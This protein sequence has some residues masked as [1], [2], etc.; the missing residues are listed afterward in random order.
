MPDINWNGDAGTAP[1]TSRYD[2]ANDNLVLAETGAGTVLL[3]YDGSEWTVVGQVN[4]DNIQTDELEAATQNSNE[5]NLTK[6][7]EDGTYT[8]IGEAMAKEPANSDPNTT[9]VIEPKATPYQASGQYTASWSKAEIAAAGTGTV[10]GDWWAFNQDSFPVVIEYDDAGTGNPLITFDSAAGVIRGHEWRGI[11]FK[12][13]TNGGGNTVLKYTTGNGNANV[14]HRFEG[15][16]FYQF[17]GPGFE[18]VESNGDAYNFTFKSCAGVVG[19]TMKFPEQTL[20]DGDSIFQ[21]ISESNQF[22]GEF[23]PLSAIGG[24]MD[25]S[26][27]ENGVIIDGGC[28]LEPRNF[29]GNGNAGQIGVRVDDTTGG[30]TSF[31]GGRVSNWDVGVELTAGSDAFIQAGR[32]KSNTDDVRLNGVIGGDPHGDTRIYGTSK[33]TAPNATNDDTGATTFS[34]RNLNAPTAGEIAP[35]EWLFDRNNNRIIHRDEITGVVDFWAS[36]GTL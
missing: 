17:G 20:W 31:V 15:V 5:K 22:V 26:T 30:T 28:W 9:H 19:G 1:Y 3:E 16:S 34:W 29:E 21:C 27:D 4:A 14:S 18:G 33:V 6:L 25:A 35:G 11:K 36:D 7:V 23:G 32:F 12:P 13:T 2:D 8:D 10:A 24:A